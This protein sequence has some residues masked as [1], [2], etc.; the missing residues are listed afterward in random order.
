MTPAPDAP[1]TKKNDDDFYRFDVELTAK[2]TYLIGNIVAQWG[3]LEHEIFNQTLL[4]FDNP[5]DENMVLPKEIVER[6]G[7]FPV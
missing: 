4:S 6:H 7:N 2:E 5:V 1:K 3:A